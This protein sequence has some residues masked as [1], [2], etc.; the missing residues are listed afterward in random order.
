[1]DDNGNFFIKHLG[2]IIGIV[3]ALILSCTKLYRVVIAIVAM[4]G[5]A[6]IGRYIQYHK[7]ETKEKL[8]NF[9]DK[10]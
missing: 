5:G 3:I 4:V 8:K 10:W 1:M 6:Y 2:A 9:I 7:E